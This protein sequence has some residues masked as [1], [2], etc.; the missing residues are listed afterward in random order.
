MRYISLQTYTQ[1]NSMNFIPLT[2]VEQVQAVH[3]HFFDTRERVYAIAFDMD[4]DTLQK[5]YPGMSWNNAYSE[6]RGVLERHS[7]AWQQ[8]RVYFGSKEVNA[9][10]CF[11]AVRDCVRSLEWF[12][13]SVRDIRMLRIEEFNDLMPVVRQ[14]LPE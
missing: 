14:S 10:G 6:I 5:S 12:A 3:S 9:V 1:G 13:G 7:F 11:L 8:G 2:S 4:T